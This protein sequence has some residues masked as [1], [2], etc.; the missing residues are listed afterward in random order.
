MLME[1]LKSLHLCLQVWGFLNLYNC[2]VK[3][4]FIAAKDKD[5]ECMPTVP[6]TN[7]LWK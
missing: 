2:K 6:A 5:K 7:L 4:T 3:V 1:I